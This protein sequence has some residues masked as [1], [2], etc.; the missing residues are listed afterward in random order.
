MEKIPQPSPEAALI[1]RIE[2]GELTGKEALQELA[3][4]KKFVFHGS[5]LIIEEFEPRQPMSHGRPDGKPAICVAPDEGY[6]LAIFSALYLT[7]KEW[8]NPVEGSRRGRFS[9]SDQ[10][11]GFEANKLALEEARSPEAVGYVYVF[12]KKDFQEYRGRKYEW[13]RDKNIKPLLVVKVTAQDFPQ[14]VK[15]IPEEE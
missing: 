4:T 7:G 11:W 3:A 1:A 12:K 6:E 13:R 14:D 8:K 9:T 10:N 15:I 5:S 2:G